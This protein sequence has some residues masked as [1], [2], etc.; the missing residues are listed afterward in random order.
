MTNPKLLRMLV[1]TSNPSVIHVVAASPKNL[2]ENGAEL[3]ER[4]E[5]WSWTKGP[6]GLWYDGPREFAVGQARPI[7]DGIQGQG[8]ILIFDPL[9][10][11]HLNGL[12]D[13][14]ESI[15]DNSTSPR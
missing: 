11:A 3:D 13:T 7:Y 9:N 5:R 8:V 1:F 2:T 15:K 10:I 6:S 12:V 14:V 4:N